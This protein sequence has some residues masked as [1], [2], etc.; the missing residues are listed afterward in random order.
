M[1]PQRSD[2][3]SFF[4]LTFA[5]TWGL[6]LPGVFAQRG[7]LPGDPKTYMPLVGLGIFGP[8]LAATIL[9]ARQGGKPAVKALYSRLLQWRVH[10][11]WYVVALVV[12]GALLAGLLALLN[13]AGRHGPLGYFPAL[14][15]ITFGIVISIAEEVGWRGY[16]LPRLQQRWG[17]FAASTLIGVLWYLWHI[18][19]FLGLGVPLNLGFVMLLHFTGGSLFFTWIYNRTG[20]SLLLAVAAHMGAHLNNSHRALPDEVL[21]VVAHAIIYAALGL[22]VMWKA[23][24]R[25]RDFNPE[26]TD[27]RAQGKLL[28]SISR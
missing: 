25:R 4:L 1:T 19:M 10:P 27:A 24:P 18:P 11:A 26:A 16:A 9:T 13:L 15:A 21:P 28:E 2:T 8:L 6:Q 3:T 5:I 22:F 23:I 20:G 14:G 12:P 17:S 7:W